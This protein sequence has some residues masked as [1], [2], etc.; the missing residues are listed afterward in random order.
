LALGRVCCKNAWVAFAGGE[1]EIGARWSDRARSFGLQ[2][3]GYN[4][5]SSLL[6]TFL[7]IRMSS[8]LKARTSAMY[9]RVAQR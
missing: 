3:K 2:S 5:R 7:G 1:P 8:R 4:A 6:A 9:R